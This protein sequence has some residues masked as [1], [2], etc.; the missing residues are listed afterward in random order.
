MLCFG[1]QRAAQTVWNG[2]MKEVFA[3]DAS[4]AMN[5]LALS[6]LQHAAEPTTSDA[7]KGLYFRQFIPS[8]T[9]V[10]RSCFVMFFFYENSGRVTV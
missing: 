3:V 1:F 5:A 4:A 8:S 9:A 7:I 2:R 10:R 6:L